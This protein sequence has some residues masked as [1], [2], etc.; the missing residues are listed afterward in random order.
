MRLKRVFGWMALVVFGMPIL[1]IAM[2]VGTIQVLDRTDRAVPSGDGERD[3]L[4]HVPDRYDPAVPT[5]LVISLHAAAMWPAHQRHAS[6]WD[7][8]ADANGFLVAYPGGHG[9]PRLFGPGPDGMAR[10]VAYI[11][12]LLDHLSAEFNIDPERVYVNGF[13]NGGGMS[14]ALSCA[15]SD[16]VAAVG[17]VAAAMTL[18]WEWCDVPA[19]M[20]LIAF[21]ST[22]DPILPYAG[23]PLNDPF[24]PARTVF[25]AFREWTGRWAVRNGCDGAPIESAVADDVTRLEYAGCA[26]APVTLYALQAGG[27]TWPGGRWHGPEWHLGTVSQSVDA[28]EL[29]W[30]FFRDHRL[31]RSA[32]R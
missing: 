11:A 32:A 9:F 8:V 17:M 26:G 22:A 3:Y 14:F 5:P 24:N 1:L 10:D 7:R 6:G 4:V 21:H 25:P 23:G 18:P 16:R 15:L 19:P 29:M 13:S 27:H 12:D 2:V 30:D 28:S 20:P 31:R